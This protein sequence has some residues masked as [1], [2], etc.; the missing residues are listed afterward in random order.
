MV[1]TATE[2]DAPAVNE[3]FG[4]NHRCTDFTTDHG[5]EASDDSNVFGAAICPQCAKRNPLTGDPAAFR[6]QV[7]RCMGCTHVLVLDG[8]AL[9]TFATEV[10]GDGE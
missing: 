3:A 10:A 5:L 4:D 2:T 7:M 6:E 1:Q 8:A 9:A